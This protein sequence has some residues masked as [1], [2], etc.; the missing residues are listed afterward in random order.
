MNNQEE[1]IEEII[2]EIKVDDTLFQNVAE[3][4]NKL[5]QGIDDIMTCCEDIEKMIHVESRVEN[6]VESNVENNELGDIGF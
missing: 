4:F 1:S 2:E 5:T 3:E 6:N